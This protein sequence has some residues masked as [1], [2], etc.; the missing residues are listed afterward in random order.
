MFVN[1]QYRGAYLMTE[2]V[3]IDKDRV[4]VDET[5]GMI[6][7]VD[8]TRSRT[9]RWLQVDEGHDRVRV[10]GPGR[11]QDLTRRPRPK[12]SPGRSSTAIKNRINAFEAKLYSTRRPASQYPEF[13]DVAS[14]IDFYL[15][16]E[17]TKDND[18]DFY[19]SHYFSWDRVDRRNR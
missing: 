16:K 11:A 4:D 18:A 6:M 2:S 17:F 13:L 3:K 10:Q 8:G 14:A 15:V 19:R 5:T 7:E 9:P 1:D 12:A